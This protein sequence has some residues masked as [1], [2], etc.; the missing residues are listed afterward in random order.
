MILPNDDEDTAVHMIGQKMLPILQ[1]EEGFKG[2]SLDIVRKLDIRGGP[3]QFGGQ[4]NPSIT[5]WKEKWN[6]VV[7]GQV[8]PQTPDPVYPEFHSAS[9]RTYFTRK[10]ETTFGNF[11][12]LLARTETFSAELTQGFEYLVPL[13]PDPEG[14]G[15]DDILPFPIL[16]S[17][18]VAPDL[19]MPAPVAAYAGRMA[20]RAGVPSVG[21][22]RA[23]V[24]GELNRQGT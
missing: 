4:P 23:A 9:A 22:L 12:G 8:I 17:L 18:T 7:N 2:E 5:A 6:S 16:R 24:N 14:A 20:E 11:P 13:L 15:I 19:A 21:T 3:R 10:K 1:D